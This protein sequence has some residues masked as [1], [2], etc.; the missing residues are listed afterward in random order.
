[1]KVWPAQDNAAGWGLWAVIPSGNREK[2]LRALVDQLTC[3]GV[4]VVVVDTGYEEEL[5][6]SHPRV[7]V[8]QDRGDKNISRWWNRGLRY[9]ADI[10]SAFYETSPDYVV[11]VLNDD[12]VLPED[13]RF[14]HRLLAV[15]QGYGVAIAYPDQHRYL[16]NSNMIETFTKPGPITLFARMPGYAFAVRGS[17]GLYADETLQWWYGDDDLDWR[18]RWM[19]GTAL[20]GN[21]RVEHLYPSQ[22]TVGKMAEQAG[23]DRQTF[24][25]KWGGKTPW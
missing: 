11:V 15:I 21:L 24:K 23:R 7:I 22:S 17:A 13:T 19:A 2:E 1:M 12:V 20:V 4:N 5:T 6:F 25:D 18:A 10:Q 9:I 8:L 16:L 14:C 3:D